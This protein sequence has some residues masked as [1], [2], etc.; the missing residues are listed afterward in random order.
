MDVARGLESTMEARI[1]C[2]RLTSLDTT[3]HDIW[4]G[5]ESAFGT[6]KLMQ[7]MAAWES[8]VLSVVSDSADDDD[9]GT[10][11]R[12]VRICGIDATL[13]T[14]VEEVVVLNG[15]AAVATTT[16]FVGPPNSVEVETVGSGETNAGNISVKAP[17]TALV[18][19]LPVGVGRAPMVRF[20]VPVDRVAYLMRFWSRSTSVAALF[21]LYAQHPTR[22]IRRLCENKFTA[23][24]ETP[25]LAWRLD[26]TTSLW[27]SAAAASTTVYAS[28][29]FDL[30]LESV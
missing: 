5:A 16:R 10:G 2:G 30:M 26:P 23:T 8:G 14:E 19:A 13:R 7:R 6:T 22:G 24:N 3:E 1:I 15:V 12:T 27:M 4:A 17:S 25:V 28:G 21:V 29:G 11:A 18:A 20:S 9:G